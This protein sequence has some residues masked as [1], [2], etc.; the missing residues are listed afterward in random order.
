M[1]KVDMSEEAIIR[2]LKRVDGLRTLCLSLM[3]AKRLS[4]EKKKAEKPKDAS[5]AKREG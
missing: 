2:R 4:D 3:E 1:K 5:E